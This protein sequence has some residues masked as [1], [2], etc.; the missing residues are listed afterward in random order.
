MGSENDPAAD[1]IA[2]RPATSF[3]VDQALGFVFPAALRAVS[4]LGVADRPA[5][6]PLPVAKLAERVGDHEGNLLRVLRVLATR[7]VF[8]ELDDGRFGVTELA[9]PLRSDAPL[10]TGLAI[11]RLTDRSLWL[12]AG[13]LERCLEQGVPKFDELFGMQFFDYVAQEER[14]ATAFH[15]GMAAFSDQ[16]NRP[17]AAAYDFPETGPWWTSAAAEA[18]SSLRFCAAAPA[19]AACCSTSRT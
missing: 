3:L 9:R 5:D 14:T 15:N 10:P 17:I 12:P 19:C 18:A 6:G 7:G 4:V 11:L 1:D 8:E 13:E 16:E 2:A